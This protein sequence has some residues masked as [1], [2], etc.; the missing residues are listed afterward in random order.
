[1]YS[2]KAPVRLPNIS[3][4]WNAEASEHIISMEDA[5]QSLKRI[6]HHIIPSDVRSPKNSKQNNVPISLK[7]SLIML[8]ILVSIA[9]VYLIAK[10]FNDHW[11]GTT[12][13]RVHAKD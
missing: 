12:G 7:I 1:M 2:L 3:E 9:L 4:D 10:S 8:L 5:G 6:R 11:Q 13:K